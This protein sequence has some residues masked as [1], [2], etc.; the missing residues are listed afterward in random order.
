MSTSSKESDQEITETTEEKY[1]RMLEGFQSSIFRLFSEQDEKWDKRINEIYGRV[2]DIDDRS[3]DVNNVLFN[4]DSRLNA[5]EQRP[6][7]REN[8][9]AT[10][11]NDENSSEITQGLQ[12]VA[13]EQ[14]DMSPVTRGSQDEAEQ[15]DWRNRT[16]YQ[17][18]HFETPRPD[19]KPRL[20]QKGNHCLSP[21][22]ELLSKA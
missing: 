18:A 9:R 3:G 22:R 16:F 12:A 17:D 5:L 11:P 2:K 21:K 8:S 13:E 6:K 14:K 7:S 15:H 1:E 4:I 20:I 19:Q 10:S